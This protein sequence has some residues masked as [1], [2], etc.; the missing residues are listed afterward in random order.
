AKTKA[1]NNGKREPDEA[2]VMK[3]LQKFLK[4]IEETISLKE[5]QGLDC[6]D[7]KTEREVLLSF[8]PEPLT[9]EELSDIIDTYIE[10][11]DEKTKKNMGKVMGR[12][13]SEYDGRFDGKKAASITAS[14]LN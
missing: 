1:I 6:T 7:D 14:K 12:L 11:L 2:L 3:T 9:E 5:K 13:K 10:E 8:M 4:S